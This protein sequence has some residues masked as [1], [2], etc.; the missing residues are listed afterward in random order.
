M[1][2]EKTIKVCPVCHSENIVQRVGWWGY[3][4][5]PHCGECGVYFAFRSETA[6]KTLRAMP[7]WK[8]FLITG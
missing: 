8:R 1:K 3:D 7:I 5:R 4:R 2:T 6:N